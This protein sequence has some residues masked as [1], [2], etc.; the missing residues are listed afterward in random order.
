MPPRRVGRTA[1]FPSSS[2]GAF[3]AH[4]G[5]YSVSPFT[6]RCQ[7]V[8]PV[9]AH[10]TLRTV[11]QDKPRPD[12]PAESSTNEDSQTTEAPPAHQ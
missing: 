11:Q 7:R 10:L 5:A 12:Q 4:P 3:I 6:T 9:D 2:P 1:L 8:A